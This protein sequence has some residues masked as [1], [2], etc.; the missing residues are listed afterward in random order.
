MPSSGKTIRSTLRLA[1]SRT[2]TSV[3]SVFD[4]GSPT[5]MRGVHAATRTKPWR[6]LEKKCC[7]VYMRPLRLPDRVNYK[8]EGEES[9]SSEPLHGTL[10]RLIPFVGMAV[11][12][13]E[14]FLAD[15]ALEKDAACA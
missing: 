1:P 9:S 13:A 5:S 14:L 7:F 6:W 15:F 12:P 10:G 2:R 8:P 11:T 3:S 4:F